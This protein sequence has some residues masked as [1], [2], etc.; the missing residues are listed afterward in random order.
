MEKTNILVVKPIKALGISQAGLPFQ[1]AV[2]V[3]QEG[4]GQAL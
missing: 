4:M 1:L 2:S 3:A